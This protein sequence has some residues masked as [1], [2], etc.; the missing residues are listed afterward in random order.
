MIRRQSPK[1]R[2]GRQGLFGYNQSVDPLQR[3]LRRQ[4]LKLA[5]AWLDQEPERLQRFAQAVQTRDRQTCLE[6]LREMPPSSYLDRLRAEPGNWWPDLA[7]VLALPPAPPSF[8]EAFRAELHYR[9]LQVSPHLWRSCQPRLEHLQSFEGL[10]GVLNLRAESELSRDLCSQLGLTYHHLPV[11]DDEAP[12][13]D[14]VQR[15]LELTRTG[16]WLVHCMAGRG[17]TG[18]FVAC[19]RIAQ[20]VTVAEALRLTES[21]VQPIN[22]VQAAFVKAWATTT[23]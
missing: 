16:R 10:G 8:L 9:A 14:Q 2:L 5:R 17:R 21:E 3:I 20:G 11:V 7:A 22:P 15:F 23:R 12:T 18:T 4:G 19:Y 13:A 1:R 6:C